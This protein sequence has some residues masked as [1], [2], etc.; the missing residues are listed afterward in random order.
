MLKRS[1]VL[2][3]EGGIIQFGQNK[4]FSSNYLNS[5]ESLPFNFYYFNLEDV[6]QLKLLPGIVLMGTG[7]VSS[8]ASIVVL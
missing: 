2:E 8:I 6:K 3:K 4:L 5:N 1:L 7:S